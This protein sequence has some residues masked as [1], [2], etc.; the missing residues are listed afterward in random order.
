MEKEI[1]LKKQLQL[2]TSKCNPQKLCRTSGKKLCCLLLDLAL[3]HC[4]YKL[5][6]DFIPLFVGRAFHFSLCGREF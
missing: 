3:G 2:L 4:V 5:S 1:D 6:G